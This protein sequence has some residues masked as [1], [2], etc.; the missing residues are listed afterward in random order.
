MNPFIEFIRASQ[1]GNITV[2]NRLLDDR[3]VDPS[4]D[5]NYAIAVASQAGHIAVVN[6]LLDDARVDP[7]ADNNFAIR[8]ASL[9]GHTPVVARLLAD[10]RVDPSADNNFAI[11][12][13]AQNGHA[14]VVDRLLS[15]PRVEPRVNRNNIIKVA[16]QN[17]HAAVVER[18]LSDERIDPSVDGNIAIKIASQYGHAPV[19]ELLL[20]DPRVDPSVDDNTPIKVA[21]QAGYIAVVTRLLADPRVDPSA[22]N[23]Y[24]IIFAAQNGHADVVKRLLAD[25]RVDPS[26]DDNIAIKLASQHDH[27][28]VVKRLLEYIKLHDPEQYD[29]I[30]EELLMEAVKRNASGENIDVLFTDRNAVPDI[31]ERFNANHVARN[32]PNIHNIHKLSRPR[33]SQECQN[34]YDVVEQKESN[35]I[36]Y[37]TVTR[38]DD[39]DMTAKEKESEAERRVIFF[40]GESVENL[41]PYTTT[42]N[43]LLYNLHNNLYSTDCKKDPKTGLYYDTSSGSNMVDAIFRLQLGGSRY[44]VYLTNLI[45]ALRAPSGAGRP[46]AR[47]RVFVVLP[48]FDANG[49]RINV[50]RT[51]G[52]AQLGLSNLLGDYDIDYTSADHCQE[53][54][55][56]KLYGVYACEGKD[57][58]PLYPVCHDD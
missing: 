16:S 45:E 2:V 12:F 15:E 46:H 20:S 33:S 25:P 4:A 30:K 44:P 47:A 41:K 51:A 37:L 24:A 1:N 56:M 50:E 58:N 21:S 18:L 34:S 38:E 5:D 54:T 31:L 28:P 52:I 10:P 57:D 32:Y 53:G 35:I 27:A 23:N 3:R 40:L 42:L 22:D 6:R 55:D 29:T 13:A 48:L 7:S 49:K 9:N 39:Q 11:R 36:E 43:Y 17:G 8:A 14:P 19:V 26:V